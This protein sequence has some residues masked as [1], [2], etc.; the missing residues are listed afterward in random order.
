MG[1][2]SWGLFFGGTVLDTV[3][4][5]GGLFLGTVSGTA[6]GDYF[7]WLLRGT[8]WVCY[9]GPAVWVCAW[10]WMGRAGRGAKRGPPLAPPPR[11]PDATSPSNH[12]APRHADS[13]LGSG[14][15]FGLC[16]A[17]GACSFAVYLL[18]IHFLGVIVIWKNVYFTGLFAGVIST[19]QSE[20]SGMVPGTVFGIVY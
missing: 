18:N 4:G 14:S 1:G 7:L 16:M 5:E 12:H 3:F 8:S 17:S 19:K 13:N 11:P 10:W 6:F 15:V 20:A 9:L 2:L